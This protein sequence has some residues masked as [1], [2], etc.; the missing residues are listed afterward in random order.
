MY[1]RC[2]S[3]LGHMGV[4]VPRDTSPRIR[5]PLAQDGLSGPAV[6]V[7]AATGAKFETHA[8]T[9]A[10]DT[11]SDAGRGGLTLG[12]GFGWLS[13]S[14]DRARRSDDGSGDAR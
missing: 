10:D 11:I 7:G 8:L 9:N 3:D 2:G 13:S 12:Y 6:A 1:V 4:Q 5:W 14:G